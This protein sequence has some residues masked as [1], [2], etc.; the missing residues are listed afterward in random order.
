MLCPSL[1]LSQSITITSPNVTTNVK[2]GD[3]FATNVLGNPWDFNQERDIGW[4]ENF[5]GTSV[6]VSGG[7]WSGTNQ[8]P[9]GYVF[10]LFPGFKGSLFSEGL[11]G[12]LELPRFGIN[13]K[14]DASKYTRLSFKLSN[15]AR[16]TLAIYWS[17]DESKPQ[18]WPDGS[19]QGATIDGFYHNSSFFPR[20]G[21]NIYNFDMSN[22]A[23]NFEVR[24][25]SWSG[26]IFGLRIDPS[27]AGGA[28]ATTNF[29]WIRLVD[30]SSAPT[31]NINWNSSGLNPSRLVT[32]YVDNNN[33][34]FDGVPLARFTSGSDPGTYALKSAILPPGTWYFYVES[35]NASGSNLNLQA[36][37]GYSAA[38]VVNAAPSGYITAPTQL[39][40]EDFAETVAGNAWDMNDATDVPN[41]NSAVWPSDWRQFSN[42]SFNGGVF[43]ATADPPRTDLGNTE[44]DAQ[45]HLNIPV[46]TPIDTNRFHYISYRM[47]ADESSYPTMNDKVANG[48]VMRPVW[49]GAAG[50]AGHGRDKAHVVYSG[51]NTYATDLADS[52]NLEYGTGWQSMGS[53][54]NLRVDPLETTLPT[55]FYLDWV[56][57]TADNRSLGSYQIKWNLADTDNSSFTV[58]L[59]YDSDNTGYNGTLITQ[60]NSV[61]AGAGSYNWNTSGLTDGQK[62]YVYLEVSDGSNTTKFYSPVPVFI[63]AYTPAPRLAH[64]KYDFDG[65]GKSDPVVY[66]M[67]TALKKVKV[68]RKTSYQNVYAGTYFVNRSALGSVSVPWGDNNYSPTVMDIDGDSRAD[69][70]LVIPSVG[71]TLMWWVSRSTNGVAYGKTFGLKG[72]TLV[73]GDY[74]GNGIDE[75]AIYRAGS[76]YVLNES[77][78]VSLVSWGLPG[79]IPVP[80][81][82]DGDGKTDYAVFRPADGTWWIL[83]SGYAQGYASN[84]YG[85]FQWGLSGDVPLAADHDRDG[86]AELIVYR[87]GE[88]NWYMRNTVNDATA[89]VQWGL[90]NFTP[91]AGTDFNGDGY[92]DLLVVD[93]N[94]LT[95]GVTWFVNYYNG[96]NSPSAGSTAI[97]YGLSGDRILKND[98]Y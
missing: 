58:R 35:A 65:D 12:D 72:D 90:W 97:P 7:V 59:Y 88:G 41:L 8:T 70:G 86:K 24:S 71:N 83:Y 15:S 38:L 57:L 21:Y 31:V 26:N 89:V 82:Y 20:S 1:G 6:G 79:D 34:G 51:W 93:R 52:N 13:H 16:S 74:N 62:Y 17:N 4:E 30:P 61:A 44:S 55:W 69:L 11:P 40:G 23:S 87:P 95:G 10:P 76:W 80:A 9:G 75:L 77:D 73:P 68:G 45:V 22:L 98:L 78:Q 85:T 36:R 53:V 25:G 29:D 64:A 66:R 67:N 33:S 46:A 84:Y 5:V 47:A 14:I 92:P 19:L 18:Y 28:G 2:E 96:F 81:D 32:V 63:G 56:K 60:L 50:F 42:Q 43:Q 91:Y 27:V 39:T 54:T 49:W 3:D 94:A 48:W 37:S